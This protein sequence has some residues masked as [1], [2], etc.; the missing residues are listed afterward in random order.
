[1]LRKIMV[2]ASAL[3]A[4]CALGGLFS[5][6]A[7]GQF[8]FEESEGDHVTITEVPNQ[9]TA[10]QVTSGGAT[11]KNCTTTHLEA[12]IFAGI[13]QKIGLFFH[14]ETCHTTFGQ[15]VTVDDNECR[16]DLNLADNETTGAVDIECPTATGIQITIGSICRYEIDTQTGLG[17]VT[18]TNV[19]TSSTR[20][21]EMHLSLTGV[22]TTRTTNDFPFL[23]P[24]G[25]SSGVWT[26]TVRMTGENT[27]GTKHIG[28]YSD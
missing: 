23:C 4:L 27:A 26:G 17:S 7:S 11:I 6:A 20:E 14:W 24:A 12:G 10:L 13:Y 5:P 25:S 18:Y 2:V 19:G 9:Q 1:M 28:L 15:E 8:E 22:T 3:L 16:W 21:L